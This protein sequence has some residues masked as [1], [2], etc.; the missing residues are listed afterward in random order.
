MASQH[1]GTNSFLFDEK[2]PPATR[3]R[4]AKAVRR[5]DCVTNYAEPHEVVDAY[6]AVNTH[7]QGRSNSISSDRDDCYAYAFS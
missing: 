5:T 7:L 6:Q 4:P 1:Y 3:T 2:A